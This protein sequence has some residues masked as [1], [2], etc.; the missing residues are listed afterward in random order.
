MKKHPDTAV[1]VESM[2]LTILRQQDGFKQQLADI[3]NM[4]SYL[5]HSSVSLMVHQCCSPGY[6]LLQLN[7]VEGNTLYIHVLV[8]AFTVAQNHWPRLS[9]TLAHLKQALIMRQC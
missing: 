4:N 2:W 5:R 8:L 7:N 1:D 3:S 6:E 9:F